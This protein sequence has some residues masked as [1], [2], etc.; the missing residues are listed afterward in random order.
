MELYNET[1]NDLLDKNNQ[2][3]EIREKDGVVFVQDLGVHETPTPYEM[4]SHL[5]RGDK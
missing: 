1:V 2:N 5:E 3:L 4:F